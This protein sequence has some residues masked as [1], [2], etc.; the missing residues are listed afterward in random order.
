MNGSDK[1]HQGHQNE[2]AED[3][4]HI[5]SPKQVTDSS[6]DSV[7]EAKVS[8]FLPVE[9]KEVVEN[10]TGNKVA[11][12]S[13]TVEETYSDDGWQEAHSKGRSGHVVGRK[14]GRR[15]PVLSKLNVHYSE[16]S[17]IRQSNY[18]QET[19]SPVQKAAAVKNIQSGFSQLKQAITQ[20][21]STGDDS[22][23]LQAKISVSKVVS[24]SPVSVSRSIS[25]KEVALA[26]P[27][28]VLRQ[29]V[30]VENVN[31]LEEKEAEPQNCGH[32]E[33]SKNEETNNV[34]DQVIQNEVAEPIHNAATESEN[35]SQDCE[36]MISC[37]SPSE[38]PVETNAS[39]LSAAAEPFNP[40]TS[41]MTSGLNSAAVTS[42]YDVTASQ[43]SLE[44]L[45]PPATTRVPCGPR[46]PLYYRTN[47]SFRMKHGFL[48]YQAP[49]MG[50]SGFGAATMMNP[51]A[52][53]FVPQRAWQSNSVD[54]N[55]QL[56]T[57]SN[58]L[59][60][61]SVDEHEKLANKSTATIDANL[62]KSIS[63]C[64]KSELA[65]QI[66]L[67]FI[68]KSVQ[69]NMDPTADEAAAKDHK[70]RASENSSDA[71]ANDS[72]IIKILYGNE[73][74]LQQ[75]GKVN[76]NKTG[77]SEGFIVVKKRR[78]RQQFTNGV[79]G[80]YNQHSICASVR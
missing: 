58:P 2:M 14:V 78:N 37:S 54:A 16:H 17:N 47:S 64:E 9:Q 20:R 62:K 77:D 23:K 39:K 45:I 28:T 74:E 53:E 7:K 51:H 1:T 12:K 42:I 50:R 31:E 52:P 10:I 13:E 70:F 48:K 36:E 24:P 63:E 49:V 76:K 22:A 35:R 25:Y 26:P 71:I 44:P 21:S 75:S 29:L 43:G 19:V 60:K 3:E 68:V 4:L 59:P 33:T 65:R 69:N 32:S 15:R 57:D 40:G 61:T 30:D 67:S 79:A 66:L 38:K 5:D 8:N 46:S 55:S 73:D 41:S 72:A 34:S 18:K 27:G 11:V 56:H 80:L 6:D